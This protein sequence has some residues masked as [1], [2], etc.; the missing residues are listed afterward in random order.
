[1]TGRE[2]PA[3]PRRV[4]RGRTG[5][6]SSM[7]NRGNARRLGDDSGARESD[8]REREARER[9][10]G[11]VYYNHLCSSGRHISRRP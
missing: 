5:P 9:K 7:R 11:P 8:A 10:G 3:G 6:G 2:A 4:G 1:M